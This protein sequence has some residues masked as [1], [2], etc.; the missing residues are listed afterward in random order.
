M[1]TDIINTCRYLN[2]SYNH[3]Q[4]KK[5]N[6][7]LSYSL[8]MKINKFSLAL[9]L[10]ALVT[11]SLTQRAANP[12][13]VKLSEAQT[14]APLT[15]SILNIGVDRVRTA[16]AANGQIYN[17]NN[18][19]LARVYSVYR[20]AFA[21]TTNY[22]FWVRLQLN[23]DR[24]LYVNSNFT[25]E[26]RPSN[27]RARVTGFDYDIDFDENSDEEDAYTELP[28]SQYQDALVQRLLRVG[29]NFV[30]RQARNRNQIPANARLTVA[31]IDEV[32]R[33]V[34]GTSTFYKFEV[35]WRDAVRNLRVD[36][37]YIV[38]Y[39][40]ASGRA[41]VVDADFDVSD[42]NDNSDDNDSD[43][44]SDFVGKAPQ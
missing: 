36:A 4:N 14:N 8:M 25:I 23:T 26:Y 20:Q 41:S 7:Y 18:F 44:Y 3:K 1:Q 13:I 12:A 37:D 6:A 5:Y 27:H 38:Q 42:N 21:Q 17:R 33:R 32:S 15:R 35:L 24:D 29:E 9:C 16:I 39:V 43:D 34:A 11:V 31:N 28:R 19:S 2:Y 10:F 30:L 40:P 22:F